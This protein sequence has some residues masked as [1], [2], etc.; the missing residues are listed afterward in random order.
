MSRSLKRQEIK[1]SL[2]IDAAKRI[3]SEIGYE[4]TT[5]EMIGD[6]V[7]LSKQTL[8]YYSPARKTWS[9]KCACPQLR[10]SRSSLC[11]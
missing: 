2:I 10:S 7:G 5:L 1:K 4:N 6:S 8:Y 11:A 3:F 9:L